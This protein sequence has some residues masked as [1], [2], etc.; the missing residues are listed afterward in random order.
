MCDIRLPDIDSP[1]RIDNFSLHITY[2]SNSA[3][4]QKACQ[5]DV[6]AVLARLCCVYVCVCVCVC[7]RVCVYVYIYVCV[8]VC[9][10]VYK[11]VPKDKGP[12]KLMSPRYSPACECAYAYVQVR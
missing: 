6:P 10:C 11:T 7:V 2:T 1:V 4:R 12:A 3:E 5:T 9:V 8:C